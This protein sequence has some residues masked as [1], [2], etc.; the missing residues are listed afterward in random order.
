MTEIREHQWNI[1]QICGNGIDRWIC[2]VCGLIVT[3]KVFERRP[4]GPCE[5]Q[6]RAG[7][8]E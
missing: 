4:V 1:Y 6:D 5:A 2:K 7:G 3:I 8:L